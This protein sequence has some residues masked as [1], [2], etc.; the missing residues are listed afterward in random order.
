MTR[1]F[2]T[3][4]RGTTKIIPS[5][6]GWDQIVGG[7]RKQ[8][9]KLVDGGEITVGMASMA[10]ADTTHTSMNTWRQNSENHLNV[11]RWSVSHTQVRNLNVVVDKVEDRGG[12]GWGWKRKNRP[13]RDNVTNKRGEDDG[14]AISGAVQVLHHREEVWEWKDV[15]LC[16]ESSSTWHLACSSQRD[17]LYKITVHCSLTLTNATMKSVLG[18]GPGDSN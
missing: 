12:P 4:K 16:L 7:G 6:T 3:I 2:N 13:R 17:Q 1:T 18:N 8:F 14:Q 10:L 15:C 11:R 9:Q 5:S